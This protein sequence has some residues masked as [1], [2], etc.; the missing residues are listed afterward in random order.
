MAVP[1]ARSPIRTLPSVDFQVIPSHL[2]IDEEQYPWYNPDTWYPR[3][4][5]DVYNERYQT[6]VKL[7]FGSAS[8]VWLCR[9]LDGHRY[10]TMKVYQQHDPQ[11][12]WEKAVYKHLEKIHSKHPGQRYIRKLNDAFEL[13]WKDGRNQCLVFDALALPIKDLRETCEDER[14]HSPFIESILS[15]LLYALD[16]LHTKAKVV[17]N[18]LWE[19]NIILST[20]DHAYFDAIVEEAWSIPM[21]RKMEGDRIV[22]HH[23]P[24][25][26]PKKPGP[27]I[28][29][30][31][32]QAVFGAKEYARDAL[33]DLYRAPEIVLGIPWNEKIDIWAVGCMVAI[34][35]T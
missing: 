33:P 10:V 1:R 4:L 27:T 24:V 2:G 13:P 14:F 31:F 6:L 28:L 18:D 3:Q 19:G 21:A 15:A 5:G 23:H 12:E 17:H 34:W 30:D 26:I 29:C 35:P 20:N 16:F 11:P 32:G 8:T 7:G 25:D 22:Y 9:D